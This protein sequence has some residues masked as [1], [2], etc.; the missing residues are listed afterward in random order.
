MKGYGQ[1]C[2]VAKGAEVFAE[3]WTPLVIREL[4]NGSTHFNDLHR[5]VPLMSRT[6]LSTRLKQL[7]KIGVIRRKR[8]AQ[9]PEYHLTAAGRDFA[10]M[11]RWLGEWG[12]RWFPS[13]FGSEELDVS[14]LMWDMHRSVKP[15]AFPPGRTSVEIE[16]SDQP[17]PKRRWWL[18]GDGAE[19]ELCPANPGYDV[20]LFVMT[21]LKTLTQVW[22]GDLT[23]RS[24]IAEGK[25][26]LDGSRTLRLCFERW[27]GLSHFADIKPVKHAREPP[28]A[29]SR[30]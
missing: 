28:S 10:P 20:N 16:V 9:G 3:R 23:V 8:G 14:L 2:P 24:A 6:L 1:F 19:V 4:L 25:I 13:K 15:D 30:L 22:M 29:K 17:E 27:L 21:D 18:V 7:E 11:V 12:Q 26:S 5:G